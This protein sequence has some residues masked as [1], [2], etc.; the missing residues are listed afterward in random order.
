MG[1]DFGPDRALL[2][3]GEVGSVLG[4]SRPR[5]YELARL[6]IL[7]GVVRLGR[8]IRFTRKG[9]DLLLAGGLAAPRSERRNAAPR[10]AENRGRHDAR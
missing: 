10:G 6:G 7:P 8:S 9:L 2:S 1:R 4:L 3:A 5:I